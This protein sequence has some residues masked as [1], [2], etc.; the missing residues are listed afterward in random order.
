MRLTF[1]LIALAGGFHP[2]AATWPF[3]GKDSNNT[4]ANSS[5]RV[6]TPAN[7][8]RLAVK[9][10]FTTAGDVSATPAVDNKNVCFRLGREAPLPG[11]GNWRSGL[12]QER[13]GVYGA[14]GRSVSGDA[15]A[16]RQC[17]GSWDATRSGA[18]R[19]TCIRGRKA[20]RESSLDSKVDEHPG[21]IV[22]QS[23]IVGCRTCLLGVASAEEALATDPAYPC[24][25]FRGSILALDA[26]DG[27]ILWK[28]Y[29]AP[30]AKG[31]SGT[32][33]RGSTPV[34]DSS[35]NSLYITTGNNYTVPQAV[36]DCID[37]WRWT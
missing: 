21:A 18:P 33:V 27:H 13:F 3:S 1:E 29:M 11:P 24:C 16:R 9:W 6:I 37:A 26:K 28:T 34:I 36:L 2:H 31:F 22:T 4:R 20:D 7:V 8:S 30:E 23:A 12:V 14:R 25:S 15:G 19:G 35:R 10:Q 32:A 17:A 5:E